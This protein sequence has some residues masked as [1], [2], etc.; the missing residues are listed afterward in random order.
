MPFKAQ[1]AV[2]YSKLVCVIRINPPTIALSEF[3]FTHRPTSDAF[4]AIH[5]TVFYIIIYFSSLK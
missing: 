5:S 2:S 3:S 4:N 1:H